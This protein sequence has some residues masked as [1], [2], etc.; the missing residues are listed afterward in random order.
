MSSSSHEDVFDSDSDSE[1]PVAGQG[2][3]KGDSHGQG[4]CKDE[5]RGYRTPTPDHWWPGVSKF[6]E[7]LASSQKIS[8]T[9]LIQLS[10]RKEKQTVQIATMDSNNKQVSSDL[11]NT[12]QQ[13]VS[14]QD[15][16]SGGDRKSAVHT[17][18]S[19]LPNGSVVNSLSTAY[20]TPKKNDNVGGQS[21]PSSPAMIQQRVNRDIS[22]TVK[23]TIDKREGSSTMRKNCST[24]SRENLQHDISAKEGNLFTDANEESK[25]I[26]QS[27]ISQNLDQVNM[28]F[29]PQ[30]AEESS[31]NTTNNKS[32]HRQ[33]K[34]AKHLNETPLSNTELLA[35][36]HQPT[37]ISASSTENLLTKVIQYYNPHCS[38]LVTT[39]P[40]F[41][42]PH[43]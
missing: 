42:L 25:K 20:D 24:S 13:H 30:H 33:S 9:D 23:S 2:Y 8:E 18:A 19:D 40:T 26:K 10:P 27:K 12:E 29:Q 16:V 28:S 3:S 39:F 41:P 14:D 31:C 7:S 1:K 36:A 21:S 5:S 34:S 15:T 11:L 37:S 17:P 38:H 43:L 22:S 6:K 32:K 4:S 35:S